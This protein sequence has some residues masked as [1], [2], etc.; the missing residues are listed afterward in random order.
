[1]VMGGNFEDYECSWYILQFYCLF[2]LQSHHDFLT[3]ILIVNFNTLK[4]M[5]N[6]MLISLLKLVDERYLFIKVEICECRGLP[7][8]QIVS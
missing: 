8:L 1:M 5:H 6:Y 7:C 2:L 4:C 3:G